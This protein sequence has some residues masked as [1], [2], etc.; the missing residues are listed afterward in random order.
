MWNYTMLVIDEHSWSLL[1]YRERH[2]SRNADNNVANQ[3]IQSEAATRIGNDMRG[4]RLAGDPPK[5]IGEFFAA[6]S[7]R[8]LNNNPF[9]FLSPVKLLL[10]VRAPRKC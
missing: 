5:L 9:F 8:L 4:I 10:K 6:A 3:D 2:I 1:L 7:I